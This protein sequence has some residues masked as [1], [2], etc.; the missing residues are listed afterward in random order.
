MTTSKNTF[1]NFPDWLIE[2]WQNIADLLSETIGVPAALIVKAENE[3]MEVFISNH[4]ENNPYSAGTK[5]TWHGLYC[6]TVIKTQKKLLIPNATKDKVWNKNP[7]VKPE[8]IAYLGFP[9]NFPDNKPFGTIC[10]LD[11][12]ERQFTLLNEKL[13]QQFKDVI[14]LDLALLK[15][16]KIKTSNVTQEIA[17]RHLLEEKLKESEKRFRNVLQD[18]KNVA[19][20]AYAP[21]GTTTYW[22]KASELLYGYTAQEALGKN[23]L[24]LIIPSE[25]RDEVSSA[26]KWMAE[27][28]QAI[29]PSELLLKRKDGTRVSVF[30]HHTIV[31]VSGKEQELFCI[32]ID[33]T[34]RKQAEDKLKE[35]EHSLRT[36]FNAMKDVVFEMDY[37]GRYINI[38][39]TSADLMAQQPEVMVGKTIHEVFP[40]QEAD[41][42]LAFVR[43]CLDENKM[44][45]IEYPMLINNKTVW[46]EGRAVPKTNNS[47]LYIGRDITERKQVEQEIEESREK[48]R[49]LSEATFESIFISEKGICIE[50]N[51]SAEKIFGYTADEAIGR[52]GTDWIAPEYRQLVMSNMLAGYELP[53]E[54]IAIK[55]DGTRFPCSIQGKMM[56]YKGKT[57][58]VT[59]LS[60]ITQR[61]QV[62]QELIAAK[63]RA[64][65]SDRLK[66]AFLANMSH[67]IRTP[68]NGILGFSSLLKEPSLSGEE[69]QEYINIIEKAGAR[70]LNTINDIISI[71]RIESGEI[72]VSL[73]NTDLN[74]QFEDV[75]NFF[76]PESEKK[77]IKFSFKTSLS[78][79]KAVIQTDREKVNT[80]LF[81]LVKNAIKYTENG[82]VEFG[83][84]LKTDSDPLELVFYIKDTGI[85][86]PKNRQKVIFE[87]FMQADINDKMAMQGSGLGLSIAK[88]YVEVLGGKIGMES[89][90][91]LGSVFYV[92]LPYHT[93]FQKEIPTVNAGLENDFKKQIDTGFSPL[94]ILIAEDDENAE[95]YL[96]VVIKSLCKEVFTAETGIEAIETCRNHPDIDLILM[97]IQMPEMN[98][99]EATRKIRE[100][101][102]EV[103]IIAQTAFALAGDR[104]KALEAGCN[105]YITKPINKEKMRQKIAK[106]FQ[107]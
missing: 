33:L 11:N 56:H 73:S 4:S 18:V 59:S 45:T 48:Y 25:M 81:N 107:Q 75:Y 30:S 64:E 38:A 66:T 23:L 51:L 17:K 99:Y 46:F 36:L 9:L 52:K 27:S 16:F 87:R 39:P 53:Y 32:D 49:G 98:G 57:V 19:V 97:D 20:Q 76:K 96:R 85:G 106:H 78:G 41:L 29:P 58:R 74:I 63:E 5:E 43:K 3:S 60:D 13:I 40:K 42:Y 69:Q 35:N 61:K 94:K 70:M 103:I 104:E 80:I 93:E 14:E 15:S 44:N 102:K 62:E 22:N 24:D 71:S 89:H 54:A 83:Y 26:I 88:A 6:E 91:G 7:D 65:Q 8:M 79:K 12:K 92:T 95:M 68:M 1:E 10:I 82:S 77:G 84:T 100:F 31:Q 105:D 47:V 34:D 67:E 37:D 72:S 90:E 28:G 55:K 86:I 2:K 101:N 21:D 50:Q